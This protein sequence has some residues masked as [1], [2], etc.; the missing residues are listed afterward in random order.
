MA[1]DH[2]LQRS[3]YE[4]KYVIDESTARTVRD[5]ARSYLQRDEHAI[6]AMGHAYPI[7]SVYLDSPA[8]TLYNSTVQGQKNRYKLRIRYYNDNPKSPVFFELKRRVHDV[9][10]KDRACVK[11]QS[12]SEL[13]RGRCPSRDDLL[14]PQDMDSYSALRQSMDLARDINAVAKEYGGGGHK[15]ASG[16]SATGDLAEL[17]RVFEQKILAQIHKAAM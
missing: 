5:F 11:R 3:R 2:Q 15:N 8:W 13:L 14:N 12:V 6:P 17:T 7:Y 4:L 10:L 1:F 9:I 16:C